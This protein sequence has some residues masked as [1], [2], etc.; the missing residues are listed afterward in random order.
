MQEVPV[1]AFFFDG[2]PP[3]KEGE[4]GRFE[5]FDPGVDLDPLGEGLA[6]DDNESLIL[7][8]PARTL[9]GRLLGVFGEGPEPLLD[10]LGIFRGGGPSLDFRLSRRTSGCP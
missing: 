9:L 8:P 6:D 2:S 5:P 3:C 1:F 7:T 4:V 10:S